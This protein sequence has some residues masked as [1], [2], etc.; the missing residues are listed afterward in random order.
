V[1]LLGEGLGH[2]AKLQGRELL[3]RRVVQHGTSSAAP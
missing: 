1:E 3:Q 2:A